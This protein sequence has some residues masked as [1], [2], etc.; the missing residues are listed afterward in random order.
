MLDERSKYALAHGEDLLD[1]EV[2]QPLLGL[3]NEL[4]VVSNRNHSVG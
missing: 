3:R 1:G 2:A 4:G